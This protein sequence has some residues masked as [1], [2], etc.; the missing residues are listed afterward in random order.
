VVF[1]RKRISLGKAKENQMVIAKNEENKHFAEIYVREQ[2][3]ILI[4][5]QN[6][7]I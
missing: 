1:S 7:V 2:P 3:F 6:L 5:R 4:F